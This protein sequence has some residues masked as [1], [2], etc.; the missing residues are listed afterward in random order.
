M[1]TQEDDGKWSQ[2]LWLSGNP[3]WQGLQM[4]EIAL[5]IILLDKCHQIK[6]IE[7]DRLKRY[8]PGAKKA[9]SFLVLNG[10]T[11]QQDRWE[12]QPGLT[13][14]TL[15]TEITALVSAAHLAEIEGE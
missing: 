9:L 14:F 7:A 11:T 4:D 6:Q 3:H 10:P 13:A 5:P 2:N 15:A 12:E 8:W 1:A